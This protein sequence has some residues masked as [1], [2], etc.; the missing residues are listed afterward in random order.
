LSIVASSVL[1]NEET[2]LFSGISL[3]WELDSRNTATSYHILIFNPTGL[4][5]HFL[6]QNITLLKTRDRFTWLF[7][8]EGV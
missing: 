7:T 4:S 5:I 1:M 2:V 3:T 6:V 8:R